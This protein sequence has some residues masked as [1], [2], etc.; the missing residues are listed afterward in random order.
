MGEKNKVKILAFGALVMLISSTVQLPAVHAADSCFVSADIINRVD[1][2]YRSGNI[3][4]PVDATCAM[5]LYSMDVSF[6]DADNVDGL[7]AGYS[8]Y[9]HDGIDHITDDGAHIAWNT[10]ENDPETRDGRPYID[11]EAGDSLFGYW[12]DIPLET[13]VF[14]HNMA[15]TIN[16]ARYEINGEMKTIENLVLD[17][18]VTITP[19]ETKDVLMISGIEK[20]DVTYT[21]HPVVLDG[22]LTVE[23]NSDG[24]TAEDLT[25]K[26]YK[27]D[28]SS[29]SFSPIERPTDP[30]N[31]YL[32]EYSFEN[33]N[34]RA[35]LRVPFTIKN[36][37]TVS[38]SIY[39][40]HGE[41][42]T[43]AYV[44]AGG[45]LHVDIIPAD[46][47]KVS[48]VDYNRQD[49]THLL[50]DDNSLDFAPIN[51]DVEIVVSFIHS[52]QV[53]Q[54]NGGI[55]AIG[56]NN[57]LSFVV[58]KDPNSYTDGEVLVVVDENYVDLRTDTVVKPETQT[59]TLLSHFLDTLEPG[60]HK[61]ELYFF[62]TDPLGVAEATFII[63]E[64]NPE[65]DDADDKSILVPST[66]GFTA[67]VDGAG[68]TSLASVVSGI[69]ITALIVAVRLIRKRESKN[70]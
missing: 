10:D 35:S 37:Y 4:V 33:D 26:Y 41:I 8:T 25:E 42:S 62:D 21:D 36:Y 22:E 15:V 66:G 65:D 40:G 32:V 2:P 30:G 54:G 47:Y 44:D 17:A 31:S 48:W 23:E 13:E 64:A 46:G 70:D 27:Y 61:F 20:Q 24:I 38:H 7:N 45:D 5:K 16:S 3:L 11:V 60:E 43:P 1:D 68:N 53:T 59:T 58:D 34:Y 50:N 63:V 19:D 6:L 56:D 9:W 12:Y 39:G 18:I 51:E 57:D 69:M 14:K 67:S 29:S 49:V 55:H 28:E 52:Y